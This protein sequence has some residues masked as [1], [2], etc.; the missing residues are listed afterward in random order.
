ML[1]DHMQQQRKSLI[2]NLDEVNSYIQSDDELNKSIV[3]ENEDPQSST[4]KTPYKCIT[5]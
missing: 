1:F 2:R 5:Y 3:F 4:Y